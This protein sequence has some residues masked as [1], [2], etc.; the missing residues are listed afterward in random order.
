MAW[1]MDCLSAV[2]EAAGRD[3]SDAEMERVFQRAQGRIRKL[4]RDGM[5]PQAAAGEAAHQLGSEI[6]TAAVIEKRNAAL[7][8]LRKQGLDVRV[9]EGSEARDVRAVLTG[10]EGTGRDMGRSIDAERHGIHAQLAGPLVG[11]LR[12]AG[13]LEVVKRRDKA[14]E[15]DVAREMWRL[16]DPKAGEP[17][18]NKH[19]ADAAAILH[20]HQERGRLMQ[21][22]AGAWIGKEDHYV[23]RQ[24]HDML[25]V[26][27]DGTDAAYAAWRDEIAPKLDE[28]TFDRL[29]GDSP[30]DR[31]AFLKATWSALA[32]GVHDTAA[33]SNWLGGFKGP[34]N[35]AKKASQERVLHFRDADA[36]YDYN[37]RF[38]KGGVVDGVLSGMEHAARNT[39]VMR[40]LGTNPEAMFEH[41][42]GGLVDRAKGRGDFKTVDNLRGDWNS[43][44]LDVVTGK[45]NVAGHTTLGTIGAG[46]RNM[47]QL[48]K[49][50]G[51]VLS[52]IPDL[53]VT[54]A[55]LR[56]NGI[57]LL[58]SYGNQI[59]SVLPGKGAARRE[60]AD[61]LATGMDATLASIH[62][63][64]RA[65]DGP[66]G[67]GAKAVELFHKLNGLTYWTDSLKDGMGAMLSRN[68]ARNAGAEF[69]ALAPRLQTTLRR[70][71]IEAGEWNAIRGTAAKAADGRE[72][73]F[74]HM[75]EGLDDGAVSHLVGDGLHPTHDAAREALGTKLQTYLTDQVREGMTEPTAGVRTLVSLGTKGGTAAG[76]IVRMLAQFK[77]YSATYVTRSLGREFRRD[78]ADVGG[79]AH[80]IA[81]TTLLGYASMT[82]KE[83][84]K[85]RNPRAP[86]GPGAYAKLVTAAMVQGGGLGIYGDF[87]F[88]EANR[89]GG[90]F[91][92]TL[93]GPAAGTLESFH[94]VLTT[95]RDGV[96]E[97]GWTEGGRRGA[98][99]AFQEAK[100]NAP[101]LNLFYARI[102]LDH[103][104][105]YKM[106]EAMNPGYLHRYE[107]QV[108]KQNNQTF[109]LRPSQP[110][111]PQLARLV[112][113]Q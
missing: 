10:V 28:R 81:M 6:R 19:A 56:H 34:A 93:A 113:A 43:R 78:G 62:N 109:W 72:Y 36:W 104:V 76:E 101:F 45:A 108:K 21:N 84:V 7:N 46:V 69:G 27:G 17:T 12:K 55:T 38:G 96:E 53:A 60:V 37:A 90:G 30:A 92:G 86:D 25:K 102:V 71:G 49:L 57:G 88:G 18:G 1:F 22:D 107:Q 105:F 64:F 52:S 3:L 15:R 91:I 111:I 13:L 44:I 67:K 26:R 24:S 79:I 42:V 41:W 103:L 85:G 2:N 29:E 82:L 58:E 98:V 66:L 23:T 54:A 99:T 14:F 32:S 51:V 63:R 77:T 83:L 112:G 40:T 48:S 9:S 106:Q 35:M 8:L 4:V 95:L 65:E 33:G 50:G 89:M 97:H 16:A 94:K 47:Q 73:V 5:D 59:M 20:K 87:L 110:A 68:L 11:D 75:V 80:L 61:H 74:S 39:A 31:E 70:Y 100:N